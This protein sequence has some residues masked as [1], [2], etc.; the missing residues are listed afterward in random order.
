MVDDS[1][2]SNSWGY[3]EGLRI[4]SPETIAARLI[5]TVSKGGFYILNI[6]PMADGIIPD[7][8][9]TVLLKLGAWL[10]TNG[11]SIYGTRPW[12]QFQEGTW[13]FTKKADT[14]YAIASAWPGPEAVI[15]SLANQKI[16]SVT[17]LGSPGKLTFTQ[18]AQGLKIKLPAEHSSSLAWS[19]EITPLKTT[20]SLN[21]IMPGDFSDLDAIRVGQ[22]Y[23]AIS[24]TMQ[25]SPGMAVLHST[26]LVKWSIIGHAVPD[27]MQISP[28][29]KKGRGIWAGALRYRN[30]KFHVYFG[31]PDE[32]IFT[33]SATNPAGPWEPL[34]TV[35]AARGWDDPCPFWDDDGQGYLVTTH[36][37]R[38]PENGKT[39]NIHLFKLTPGGDRVLPESDR[40]LYQAKGSEANKLYKINGTYYHLFSEVKPEGRML[41]MRRARSLGGPWE[42]KQLNKASAA[43]AREPNQGGLVQTP[44]GDWFFVTHLGKGQWEGRP[45]VLLPVTWIDGWPIPGELGPDQPSNETT[46][47]ASDDFNGPALKPEW[48]WS[49][50]PPAGQW[51]L[52][53][54]PGFLRLQSSLPC[55]LTQRSLRAP[56]HEVTAK[57]DLQGLA[58]GQE[59]GLTHFGATSCAITALASGRTRTLTSSCN[60]T[61]TEGPLIA[62]SD[63]WL[64]S[65]WNQ[66]GLSQF[67]YSLD[68]HQFQPIGPP[69]QLT[70]AA[71]RGDRIGL[72]ISKFSANSGYV[73][74]DSFTYN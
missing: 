58:S 59:A 22:D 28:E 15:S 20:A 29:L 33:T 52:T 49:C 1:I 38:D 55:I 35:M 57:L 47:G 8:Q 18:D 50:A 43:N 65:E 63:L 27:T 62:T 5:D 51:S 23:Y 74:V 12:T 30:G 34:K 56:H 17:L 73:D 4:A 70:W 54:R 68:G 9:Q 46:L 6:S 11:E 66:D 53:K 3:I 2:G 21:P 24:S 72:F 14:I 13:H 31:T 45:G 42:T 26:D 25:Y 69:Y 32:G 19:F 64:R 7:D 60:G 67:S 44:T 37:E 48:E 61:R 41:M 71:Y 40:I 10:D 39:Y 16:E 36:F